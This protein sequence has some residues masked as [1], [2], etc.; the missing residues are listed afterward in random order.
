MPPAA[1]TPSP[2]SGPA[3]GLRPVNPAGWP[4]PKGYAN[5]MTGRGRLVFVAGQIGWTGEQ[6]FTTDDFVGQF[7]QALRN[8]VA[9]LEAAGAKPEHIARMTWYIIDKREYLARLPEIGRC[10]RQIIGR[11][12]PAMA[13]VQ[14]VALVEDRAKIEIETTA[15]IPDAE[16]R[17]E[18]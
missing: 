4:Q 11:H 12:F 17:G 7:E 15:L 10:W 8:T 2:I 5:G 14:V 16:E 9:V 6:I 3:S 1:S 18:H 13:L